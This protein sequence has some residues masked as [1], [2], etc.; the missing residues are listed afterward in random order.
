MAA[1][2]YRHITDS[3]KFNH[4]N[5]TRI[6]DDYVLTCLWNRRTRGEKKKRRG[7]FKKIPPEEAATMIVMREK[8]RVFRLYFPSLQQR[9]LHECN[10]SA[11]CGTGHAR[12]MGIIR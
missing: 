2:K 1:C 8:E 3:S 5:N 9:L 12:H 11:A 7:N 4:T 6:N 10:G